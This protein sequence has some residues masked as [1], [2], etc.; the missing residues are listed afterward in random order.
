MYPQLA[1]DLESF[2]SYIHNNRLSLKELDA[3]RLIEYIKSYCH[4]Q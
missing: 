1:Y 3:I 2:R 4:Y